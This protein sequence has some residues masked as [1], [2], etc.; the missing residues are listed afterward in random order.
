MSK[1]T[2]KRSLALGALMAIVITGSAMVGDLSINSKEIYDDWKDN[3]IDGW[4]DAGSLAIF[5]NEN[6]IDN[7]LSFNHNES[8][9]GLVAAFGGY[10]GLTEMGDVSSNNLTIQNG[11]FEG[12]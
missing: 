2:L 9:N 6:I 3:G 7:K 4:S 5:D 1:K 12:D 11:V 8:F 10:N